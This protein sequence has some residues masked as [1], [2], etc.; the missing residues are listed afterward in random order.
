MQFNILKRVISYAKPYIVYLILALICATISVGLTLFTPVLIG[1]AIDLIVGKNNVNI[2][3]VFQ[4]LIE[5]SI[6][7]ALTALFQWFMSLCTNIITH[8]TVRDIR[9]EAF[10]R[11][12]KVPLKYIDSTAHGDI[13]SRIVNDIDQISD[14]LIQGFTQ[15]FTGIIT[16][17]GTLIFMLTINLSITLVVVIITPLSL[18]VASFIAKRSYEMFRKQSEIRG[19]IGGYMEEMIGNQKIVKTF[20]YED[21]VQDRFEKINDELYK[22]G[23]KAQF[24]SALTNPCTRFVNGIVYAAV[25]I[26]GAIGVIY[27]RITVGQLSCFLTYA[28]QYTKP[29]NE[30]SSVITE[31]QSAIASA[32]RVFEMLDEPIE[33]QDKPNATVLEQ[34]NG[35]VSINDVSFSY[36]KEKKLI[37]NLNVF[38]NSG[39]RIAIVGPTGCGKTT[40]INLLM[41]FYDVDSGTIKVDN[42]NIQDMTR[43]SLRSQFGMVLQET[44]IFAGTV[45]DNIAYGKPDATKDEIIRAAKSAHAHSFIMRLPQG[46]D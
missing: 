9:V 3:G 37:Q 30:I 14:G 10:S 34:C 36:T 29:F 18:F 2:Q 32:G 43:K 27:G 19:E 8:R 26:I 17:V 25:G 6:V 22:Y 23:F 4:I 21:E 5:L 44:W 7:V 42:I 13:I 35:D 31:L 16:I 20:G 40:L 11:L 38:A 46:Y 24:Y 12:E 45:L 28:N 15:L 39:Q 33:A 41:R 1:N